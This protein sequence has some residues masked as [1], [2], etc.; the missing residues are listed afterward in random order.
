MS[1]IDAEAID[2][3]S[4]P[5]VRLFERFITVRGHADTE[6]VE[7]L[8][9]GITDVDRVFVTVTVARTWQRG[10]SPTL[11]VDVLQAEGEE[12]EASSAGS[13]VFAGSGS[14]VFVVDDPLAV[15]SFG[16]AVSG[17]SSWRVAVDVGFASINAPGGTGGPVAAVD[18]SVDPVVAGGSD[19]QAALQALEA[20]GSFNLDGGS[21]SSVYTAGQHIDG[22]GA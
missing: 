5:T 15:L 11:T 21:P 3:T 22:G 19:V 10:G 8:A 13:H 14:F 12:S 1:Q 16:W 7:P 6:G 20:S 4:A 9:T 18:V 17:A 2:A